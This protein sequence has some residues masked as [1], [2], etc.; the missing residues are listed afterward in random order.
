MPIIFAAI[1]RAQRSP[2]LVG[3]VVTMAI[4]LALAGAAVGAIHGVALVKLA[5]SRAPG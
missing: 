2:M 4:A 3:G 1:D 5:A